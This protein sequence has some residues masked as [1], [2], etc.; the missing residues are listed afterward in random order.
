MSG[1]GG[2]QVQAEGRWSAESRFQTYI[3][4]V[5]SLPMCGRVEL[6]QVQAPAIWCEQHIED[7]LPDWLQWMA[8]VR[9]RAGSVETTKRPDL[10]LKEN[11]F[12]IR[13]ASGK[14][15]EQ[16][17]KLLTPQPAADK[18]SAP[19]V[20]HAQPKAKGA[21]NAE[22]SSWGLGGRRSQFSISPWCK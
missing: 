5:G 19:K 2:K 8:P 16:L 20:F 15:N 12:R 11:R 3:D 6:G 1:A 10:R 22:A 4:V 14:R 21:E 7:A 13:G 9:S 17:Q 18:G